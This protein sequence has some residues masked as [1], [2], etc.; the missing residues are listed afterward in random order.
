MTGTILQDILAVYDV[1]M[2][3]AQGLLDGDGF[4]IPL[5][6]NMT[7]PLGPPAG[8]RSLLGVGT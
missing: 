2:A 1:T 4:L 3:T 5:E 7:I 8:S 6:F